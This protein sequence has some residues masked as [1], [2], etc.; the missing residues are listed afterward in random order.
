MINSANWYALVATTVV[1]VG[2]STAAS[3][4]TP[5]SEVSA[6][7]AGMLAFNNHC[8]ECHSYKQG[9]NRLGPSLYG[10][11]GRKAGTEP[12]YGNYSSSVKNSGLTWTPELLDKWITNPQSVAPDNNMA[13]PYPG[14]ADAKQR[15]A[16]IAFLK[17]DTGS[18]AAGAGAGSSG[19]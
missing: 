14:L 1:L 16:I 9:D 6:N 5:A 15:A 19:K 17:S 12:G 18:A 10:V 2:A 11:V 4:Q 8:R 3:A 13:P 7:D